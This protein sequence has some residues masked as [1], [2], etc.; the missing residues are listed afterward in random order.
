MDQSFSM[1]GVSP[2]R[3]EDTTGLKH[4]Q[5]V[6]ISRSPGGENIERPLITPR[7]KQDAYAIVYDE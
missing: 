5:T 4:G 2:S 7:I 6:T 1:R 3:E